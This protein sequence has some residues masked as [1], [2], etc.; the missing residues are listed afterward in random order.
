MGGTWGSSR[1]SLVVEGAFPRHSL[2]GARHRRRLE[3]GR[4]VGVQ[5]VADGV[6]GGQR[7]LWG[8]REG[9]LVFRHGDAGVQPSVSR[10]LLYLRNQRLQEGVGGG[11]GGRGV[12][13]G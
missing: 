11:R 2:D 9:V 7:S 13:I 4:P 6:D 10:H 1:T 3:C 12:F 8:Q 5:R